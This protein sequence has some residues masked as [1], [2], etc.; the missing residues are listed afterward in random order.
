MS[1]RLP[2][3]LDDLFPDSSPEF[4]AIVD[5]W[6]SAV[7]NQ[8][9]GLVWA[10][11]DC[12]KLL[13]NFH[14]LDFSRNYAQLERSLTDLHMGE[15]TKLWGE[16]SSQFQS[17]IPK[18]EAWEFSNLTSRA[19][20]PASCDIGFVLRSN[21]RIRWAIE[22]KV[23]QGPAAIAGYLTDLQ[24]YLDGVSAPFSTEAA[25]GAYLLSGSADALFT[26]IST[27]IAPTLICHSSF[28]SRPHRCSEHSRLSPPSIEG[29]PANFVCHHLVFCLSE[30]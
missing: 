1:S 20:R 10:G 17:F 22:A 21:P 28:Q 6:P 5:A 29:M 2:T 8:M 19:A 12:L 30:Q 24:K 25:L 9:L 14:Q 16:Q 13:P 23:L 26:A 18:H 27:K 11:F 3:I 4:R 15:I 7:V